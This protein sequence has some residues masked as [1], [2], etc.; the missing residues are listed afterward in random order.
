MCA[1]LCVAF[2]SCEYDGGAAVLCDISLSQCD[3]CLCALPYDWHLVSEWIVSLLFH[4]FRFG[5]ANC[6]RK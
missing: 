3:R 6:E 4:F 5:G 1:C 2:L